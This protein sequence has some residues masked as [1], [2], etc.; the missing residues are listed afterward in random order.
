MKGFRLLFAVILAPLA[1]HAAVADD[2]NDI[3]RAATRRD[4][5][6]TT[7]GTRKKSTPE[8]KSTITPTTSRTAITDGA[9]QRER[10]TATATR[11]A[12]VSAPESRTVTTRTA[13]Q[14]Q[15]RTKRTSER[16]TTVS[17][18][19][20]I[21]SPSLRAPSRTQTA[22]SGTTAVSPRTRNTTIA[23][24]AT[25]TIT[26]DQVMNRDFSKCKTVFFDCMDEFC[27]NKDS[28]LRRCA[29]SSRI[30]EFDNT[31]K[32]L[33]MVEDKLLD[34]SERL[35]TVNL[36]KEDAIAMNQATEGEI[37]FSQADKSASKKM[38]D[39]I[40]KKLN[41]SFDDSNFDQNLNAISLSLN[42]DAAF[43]SI[44]SFAGAS[45]T[46]KSGTELY[47]AALP[48]CRE[49]ALEIC[50]PDDLA[51]AENGYQM[52]I[53]QDCNTVKKSYQTQVDQ[54][55][56]KVF[57]SGALLDISRLDI[58][59]KRNSDDILTCKSKMLEMLT[60]STVCGDGLGKCLDTTGRYIDPTTGETFLTTYL[61]DLSKL[62]TR[63]VGN[64]TWT[65]APGN[66]RFVQYLNSKKKFLEPA[67]AACEDIS[68][69]VWDAFIEDA[70]AQIKLAQESKLNDVRQS[71]TT[72]VAQCM[73]ETFDSIADFDSRALSIFGVAADKTVNAMCSDVQVACSALMKTIGDPG[74]WSEGITQIASDQTY[75]TILKTCRE[76]GRACI[77]QTCTSSKGNFGLCENIDTSI[78]RKSIINRTACWDEVYNCVASAGAAS[79]NQIQS[80]HDA[81]N[82]YTEMYGT[83][84]T[85]IHE[86]CAKQ[87]AVYKD[88]ECYTCRLTE[89]I[90]GNCEHTPQTQLASSTTDQQSTESDASTVTDTA[91]TADT[92]RIKKPISEIDT[93][94]YWFA[95]NTGTENASDSC[96]DTSCN[97]GFKAYNGQC[98]PSEDFTSDGAYCPTFEKRITV[99]GDFTN[100][101]PDGIMDSFGNCCMNGHAQKLTP[102]KYYFGDLPNI[103]ICTPGEDIP[104]K[105]I[106]SYKSNNTL[107]E[108]II[109]LGN[110]VEYPNGTPSDNFPNGTTIQCLGIL[111][112]LYTNANGEFVRYYSPDNKIITSYYNIVNG[113]TCKYYQPEW[114]QPDGTICEPPTKNILIEYEN[115]TIQK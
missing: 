105:F 46:T 94:L 22:R 56:T 77:I 18:A 83:T 44:D 92:N 95:K 40:A 72:L 91:A 65:N 104:A 42:A 9:P 53:E 115:K 68:D 88:T 27:A 41:T 36:D 34:F 70:L 30:N 33:D 50:S 7:A 3:A 57:E 81:D 86:P 66:D 79:L 43:D 38:L 21:S 17:R 45:T 80:L 26:P 98:Y 114:R 84:P 15:S 5:G 12:T 63:P 64:Q 99:Y 16:P 111:I 23:R 25:N 73:N 101:C 48:V 20:T 110:K 108:N 85:P 4:I 75:E 82:F 100:C 29:C 113:V 90:W 71:C 109:C 62:I 19:T 107:N 93:L 61:A 2:A 47:T 31:K 67:M 74:D 89:R 37:A 28:Q 10:T 76:V 59:Q 58:H 39:E 106:A 35:L 6:T 78:N 97:A 87:C 102:A 60:D 54:A 112:S 103:S 55:R 1:F 96:R 13:P 49:M 52:A 11:S 32:N 69:Y 24:N 51:I 14:I 8:A